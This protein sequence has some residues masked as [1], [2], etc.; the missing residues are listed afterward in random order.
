M[1]LDGSQ[2]DT[3]HFSEAALYKF[4]EALVSY[5]MTTQEDGYLGFWK[6]VFFGTK[7]F[8]RLVKQHILRKPCAGTVRVQGFAKIVQNGLTQAAGSGRLP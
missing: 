7:F 2:L 5:E 3:P 8:H 4:C 6:S 1:D